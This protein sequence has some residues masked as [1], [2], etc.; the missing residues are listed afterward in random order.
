MFVWHGQKLDAALSFSRL[1]YRCL[2]CTLS[3][4]FLKISACLVMVFLHIVVGFTCLWVHNF[5]AHS[6]GLWYLPWTGEYKCGTNPSRGNWH[7]LA[8]ILGYT[9]GQVTY[10]VFE[11]I[12]TRRS[13]F[14]DLLVNRRWTF[15]G[16][17]SVCDLATWNYK[18]SGEWHVGGRKGKNAVPSV[19]QVFY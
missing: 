2:D 3:P 12:S 15:V 17:R 8:L 6:A 19:V 9:S 7:L 4:H 11:A 5:F 16:L 14:N 13:H 1:G 10:M 18:G